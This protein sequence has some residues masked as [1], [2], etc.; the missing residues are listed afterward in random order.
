[1]S[2]QVYVERIFYLSLFCCLN[3]N[4]LELKKKMRIGTR[5]ETLYVY[6]LCKKKKKNENNKN[7][8][9]TLL[10]AAITNRLSTV[11]KK[12]EKRT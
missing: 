6:A 10:T 11:V 8:R 4:F 7:E 12:G 2:L 5:L 1:M 3:F 9:K